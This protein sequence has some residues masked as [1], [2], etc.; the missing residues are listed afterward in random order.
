MPIPLLFIGAAAAAA[1]GVF[2]VGKTVKAGVDFAD[3]NSTNKS[4]DETIE[5]A[6][7]KIEKCR[8][9]C[10]EALNSL[11]EQ[12]VLVLNDSV[13]LFIQEFEKLKNVELKEFDEINVPSGLNEFHK[14]DLDRGE[15]E[16][17]KKLQSVAAS[18][19]GGMASGTVVGAATA[20]GAF[21]AASTFATASTGTA[22][23][24]L[25]GAAATNATLA[26]FGG[27]SL[28]AG[29]L[30]M[31]GGTLVLGG[32]IGGPA[33][34]ALGFFVGAKASKNKEEAYDNLAKAKKYEK[35][36]EEASALCKK[37]RK[38]ANL[39]NRMLLSLNTMFEPKIYEMGEIIKLRGTDYREF[40]DDEKKSVDEALVLAGA[41]KLVLDTPLLD[42]DGNLTEDSG[43]LEK[44][45]SARLNSLENEKYVIH[46]KSDFQKNYGYNFTKV[47]KDGVFITGIKEFI[48]GTVYTLNEKYFEELK[49]KL[50]GEY[51]SFS[52][53]DEKDISV[54]AFSEKIYDYFEKLELKT[55]DSFVKLIEKYLADWNDLVENKILNE[56]A[57]SEEDQPQIVTRAKKY[58]SHA[59]GI[60]ETGTI[61]I[62]QI[63]DYSR[64]MM[65]LYMAIIKKR[66]T[67]IDDFDYSIQ[68]LD[69]DRI[70]KAMRQK[71]SS[72]FLMFGGGAKFD[73]S[74][75]CSMDTGV[76]ILTIILYYHIRSKYDDT[77]LV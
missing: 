48:L 77:M 5:S 38:R 9:N 59:M 35:E 30:G 22:I 14:M 11:G 17:L 49:E 76:F 26:F 36:M 13:K 53:L 57:P 47:Y 27:G 56:S 54:D 10:G 20:F 8:K 40:S 64:I 55:S 18:I 61:T 41:I 7:S 2:G 65:S 73:T 12:K 63:A 51:V 1:S 70:L 62:R 24:T 33:L 6:S 15:L 68:C 42:D 71:K 39:F 67:E 74:D 66:F 23:A 29:G 16:E 50:I 21:G 19:A 28:A 25:S 34:V 75:R 31:A 69:L 58:Y 3:A 44:I 43:R 52:V 46:D 32:I 60:K 4:A 72:G 37:I 45:I